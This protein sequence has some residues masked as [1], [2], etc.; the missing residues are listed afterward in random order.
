MQVS[1]SLVNYY[2]STKLYYIVRFFCISHKSVYYTPCFTILPAT[3]V[4]NKI[5][6][7]A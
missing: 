2:N 6:Y 3:E 1:E 4:L 5:V 7:V